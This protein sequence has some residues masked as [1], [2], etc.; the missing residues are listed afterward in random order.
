MV[1][2]KRVSEHC[3]LYP[4]GCLDPVASCG[5]ASRSQLITPAA[6]QPIS[7]NQRDNPRLSQRIQWP[8]LPSPDAK[9]G[10]GLLRAMIGRYG[11]AFT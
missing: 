11:L 3:R 8:S 1:D 9:G 5:S 2:P 4:F 6:K 10:P 7:N